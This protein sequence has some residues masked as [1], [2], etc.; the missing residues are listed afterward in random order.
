VG[1]AGNLLL[2]AGLLAAASRALV[3]RLG[4]LPPLR[5]L[6]ATLHLMMSGGLVRQ[7]KITPQRTL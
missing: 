4:L 6:R 5:R 7:R 2:N 1:G 3:L